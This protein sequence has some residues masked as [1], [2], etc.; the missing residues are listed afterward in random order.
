LKRSLEQLRSERDVLHQRLEVLAGGLEV[1]TKSI[2]ELEQLE[3]D[4]EK[5]MMKVRTELRTKY[6][7]AISS[8]ARAPPGI[9]KPSEDEC[10][11]CM[12]RLS[13]VRLEP[14]GHEVLCSEC[15]LRV[16][17]CPVDR[18]P[19]NDKVLTHGVGAYTSSD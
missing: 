4:L 12:E 5:A 18:K 14:C 1:A 6:R 10:V 19:I 8:N 2:S 16:A 3:D 9:P 13:C 17:E 15:S 11:V 7:G